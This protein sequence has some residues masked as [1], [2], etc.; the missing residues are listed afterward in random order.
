[1]NK[2]KLIPLNAI[3]KDIYLILDETDIKENFI[4]EYLIRGLEQLHVK[5]TLQKKVKL[6][7]VNN[8]I[9]SYPE[10]MMGLEYVLYQKDYNTKLAPA[11]IKEIIEEKL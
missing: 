4:M 8:H 3:M 9:A 7:E 1:M 11:I 10:C 2:Y 6:I 5:M